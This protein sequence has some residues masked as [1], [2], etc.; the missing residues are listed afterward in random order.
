S[1]RTEAPGP[2][3][4]PVA[5][6]APSGATHAALAREIGMRV[7]MAIREGGREIM[8][9]LR[10]PELGHLIVRV[11][12]HDGVMQA[13]IVADRPEA[14]R[15]L[16][17]AM[18]RLAEAL[19]DQGYTLEG[20]DVSYHGEARE[21]PATAMDGRRAAPGLMSGDADAEDGPMS[22]SSAASSHAGA[23][24]LDLLA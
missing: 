18:P 4:A 11:V 9:D 1:A 15:M 8:L 22:A 13:H 23:P 24:R 5:A 14:A 21:R 6:G 19:S 2:P 12:M 17:A 3:G 16:E 7:H 10:P 20:M